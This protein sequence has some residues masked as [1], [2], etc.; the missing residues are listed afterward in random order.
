MYGLAGRCGY[1][2]VG[3]EVWLCRVGL[4]VWLCRIGLEVWLCMGWLGGVWLCMGWL[5]GKRRGEENE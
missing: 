4:E 3:W 5:G 2:G 1:V